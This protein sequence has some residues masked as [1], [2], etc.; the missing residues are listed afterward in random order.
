[1]NKSG[2]KDY[3]RSIKQLKQEMDLMKQ[4]PNISLIGTSKL[5]ERD[6]FTQDDKEN[7]WNLLN[8][9]TNSGEKNFKS[10]QRNFS[11]NKCQ[12]KQY[13]SQKYDHQIISLEEKMQS[14][15]QNFIDKKKQEIIQA[16]NQMEQLMIKMRDIEKDENINLQEKLRKINERFEECCSRAKEEYEQKV[17]KY[18][19]DMEKDIQ[20]EKERTQN[21]IQLQV[22]N[23]E[24]QIKQGT[25]LQLT[26]QKYQDESSLDDFYYSQKIT[27]VSQ[28]KPQIL[29]G[30]TNFYTNQEDTAIKCGSIKSERQATTNNYRDYSNKSNA[31]N[32]QD[33]SNFNRKG[34]SHKQ[35]R[36]RSNSSVSSSSDL[37][38]NKFK[39][40]ESKSNCKQLSSNHPIHKLIESNYKMN[41]KEIF[42]MIK[43]YKKINQSY[44]QQ[45][46][47]NQQQMALEFQQQD[48]VK[49]DQLEKNFTISRK[50]SY[51]EDPT[52]STSQTPNGQQNTTQFQF[53]P[54]QAQSTA[55][56][57][58]N[59]LNTS[60]SNSLIDN[61]NFV[62]NS[63]NNKRKFS[64]SFHSTGQQLNL[65]PKQAKNNDLYSASISREVP[66][67]FKPPLN[68]RKSSISHNSNNLSSRLNTNPCQ[69]NGKYYISNS[70]NR[71][72]SNATTQATKR[73]FNNQLNE[74]SNDL[75]D[76]SF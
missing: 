59:S 5:R 26:Q 10:N 50:L 72:Q 29:F 63:S 69:I 21:S 48:N 38:D 3:Q 30:Q 31:I 7:N 42:Q 16:Q 75:S 74:S 49:L 27:H 37:E 14:I 8:Q 54:Q 39:K 13:Q 70:L 4:H 9:T 36:S 68:S 47:L 25:N 12:E 41:N 40:R 1:M 22:K 65:L 2:I 17:Q 57:A 6:N 55:C 43:K 33:Y 52:L 71:K 76:D 45:Q 32:Q 24:S 53:I 18:K 73:S 67:Q 11:S 15:K 66:I 51:Q 44:E 46:T 56:N 28:I 64:N 61:F 60:Y 20:K 62:N 58:Q 35:Q 19:E 34:Q 23:L